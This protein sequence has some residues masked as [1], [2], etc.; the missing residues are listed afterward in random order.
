MGTA[1]ME[2]WETF[3]KNLLEQMGFGDYKVEVDDAH[4]HGVIFIHDDP[5][6]VKENLPVLVESLNHITQLAARKAGT[7]AIFWD[8]NNY[9]K[10]RE[11]LITE[12]ARATAR[13]VLATKQEIPLPVMNSY[14]RRLA[15]MEL[16]A[17]PD[18]TTESFGKGRGRY[19]VVKPLPENGAHEEARAER[20]TSSADVSV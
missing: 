8:I 18:V 12:L 16:A 9:R 19:V 17:H 13:K 5:R 7:Q 2:N 1:P 4:R 11:T 20:P 14:E 6:L 3:A 10:E 15:H